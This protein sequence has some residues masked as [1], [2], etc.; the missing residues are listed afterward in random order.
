[1]RFS[2][3]S[4]GLPVYHEFF[5]KFGE[6]LR[7]NRHGDVMDKSRMTWGRDSLQPILLP[8][9]GS[10]A[11]AL[12]RYAG[13]PPNR[14]LSQRT[15]NAGVSW[16]EPVKTALPNPNAAVAGI[17]IEGGGRMLLVFN[18]HPEERDRL[19]L[20]ISEDHGESWKV[21]HTFEGWDPEYE[22]DNQGYAYPSLI[23]AGNG[24]FHLV[25]SW[26]VRRI[27]HIRF[28]LAWLESK[29]Q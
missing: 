21:I 28:N 14:I 10:E 8:Y 17:G 25:Y 18:D 16:P 4:L 22:L 15:A 12:L 29:L 11:L 27:K 9:S 13:K 24:D 3:G 19:S 2:D 1:M 23:Q 6:L 20:A 7:L 5:A 26:N